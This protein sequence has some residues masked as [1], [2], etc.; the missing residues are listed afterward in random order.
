MSDMGMWVKKKTN[1]GLFK[2]LKYLGGQKI[3]SY[4]GNTDSTYCEKL[5]HPNEFRRLVPAPDP[6]PSGGSSGEA[7][8]RF[9]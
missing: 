8:R 3:T 7:R 1:H 2:C 6:A 9:I 4:Y 5:I